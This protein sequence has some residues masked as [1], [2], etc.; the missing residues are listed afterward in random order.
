M[1]TKPKTKPPARL[2]LTT[3]LSGGQGNENTDRLLFRFL[4]ALRLSR[5]P[6]DRSA[7]GVD[8]GSFPVALFGNIRAREQPHGSGRYL[9]RSAGTDPNEATPGRAN[10]TIL[11]N[12]SQHRAPRASSV[13][14]GTERIICR[15]RARVGPRTATDPYF[16]LGPV[17][18][19][20]ATGS[21]A[22]GLEGRRTVALRRGLRPARGRH[23][24]DGCVRNPRS[25]RCQRGQWRSGGP[26]SRRTSSHGDA[27]RRGDDLQPDLRVGV[28]R[29]HVHHLAVHPH[30][31]VPA[32]VLQGVGLTPDLFPATFALARHA[33]WTAHILE[34][35]AD[36]RLIRPSANYAGPPPP[37]P[38]PDA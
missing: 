4:F 11:R 1:K 12:R 35:A 38:V 9:S 24:R 16:P 17:I 5:L 32:P 27:G 2:R 19:P 3:P 21:F 10:G 36:N 25:S 14:S 20:G 30:R 7:R 8:L 26:R 33:G 31:R 37:V 18:P 6:E 13:A 34:Q 23:G 29:V 28:G 15:A 22:V